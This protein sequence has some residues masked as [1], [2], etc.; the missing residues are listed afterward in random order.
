MCFWQRIQRTSHGM[1]VY[2]F[3][4]FSFATTIFK[5][6][7][8]LIDI[9]VSSFSL[10]WIRKIQL[11]RK[12]WK[13]H[14]NLQ[15]NNHKYIALRFFSGDCIIME[16]EIFFYAFYLLTCKI[17]SK[18]GP[19][20]SGYVGKDFGDPFL[21]QRQQ[22]APLKNTVRTAAIWSHSHIHR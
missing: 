21:T 6:C 12:K 2:L 16:S 19:F 13:C 17:S 10:S 11:K 9:H 20:H 22:E 1:D 4:I 5:N 7:M 3:Y 14:L 18:G 8:D 15:L